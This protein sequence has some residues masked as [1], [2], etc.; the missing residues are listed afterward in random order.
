M[1]SAS[2]RIKK[3]TGVQP[4]EFELQVAQELQQLEV[5]IYIYNS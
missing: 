1:S 3:P 4:T 5:I 2:N